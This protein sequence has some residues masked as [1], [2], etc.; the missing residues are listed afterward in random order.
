MLSVI[1]SRDNRKI[2]GYRVSKKNVTS[3]IRYPIGYPVRQLSGCILDIFRIS[4]SSR[5]FKENEGNKEKITIIID[6]L[7]NRIVSNTVLTL[8]SNKSLILKNLS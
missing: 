4:D 6:R 8:L 2:N 3:V 5:F 1:I 7:R